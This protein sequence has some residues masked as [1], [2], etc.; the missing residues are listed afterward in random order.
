MIRIRL[1]GSVFR[2]SPLLRT[3]LT[4]IRLWLLCFWVPLAI[5]IAP[6]VSFVKPQVKIFSDG[7]AGVIKQRQRSKVTDV[8][9]FNSSALSEHRDTGDDL[10]ARHFDE[11]L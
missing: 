6:N 11:L 9:P 2:L 7:L 8:V 3:P 4:F 10:T 1:K 5:I